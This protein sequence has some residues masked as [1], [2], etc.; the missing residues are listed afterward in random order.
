MYPGNLQF[1]YTDLFF[2]TATVKNWKHLLKPDKYKRII[3]DSLQ[4]LSEEDT[5]RVYAFV[6]MPNHLHLIWQLIGNQDL[7]LVQLRFLKYVAQNIKYDLRDHHPEILEEFK[8]G[9]SD[10]QYQFFKERPLSVPLF[11][12]KI[13]IQKMNYL[14]QNP[15]QP[16]WHL[17]PRAEDYYWSSAAFY[18]KGD[19]TWPFLRHFWYG[20]D[21]P[22]PFD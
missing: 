4:F 3:T 21:W 2:T 9:R 16:K 1:R 7:P 15:M 22:P 6:I 8:V 20:E 14:H 18:A 5:V 11:S 13:V 19:L 10:R 17:A 12:D